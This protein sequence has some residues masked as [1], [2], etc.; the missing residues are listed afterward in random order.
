MKTASGL[1]RD[2]Y[3]ISG[4]SYKWYDILNS[5]DVHS[6]LYVRTVHTVAG[7]ILGTDNRLR[8]NMRSHSWKYQT[9]MCN[10]FSSC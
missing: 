9:D 1:E 5:Y 8:H 3:N 10:Q 4:C 2:L 6:F 7:W